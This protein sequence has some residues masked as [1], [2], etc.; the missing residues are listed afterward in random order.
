MRKLGIGLSFL[1]VVKNVCFGEDGLLPDLG[2]VVRSQ[3]CGHQQSLTWGWWL[4]AAKEPLSDR[5]LERV[6]EG[7]ALA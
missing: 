3:T 7:L 5:A 6:H 2:K 4:S 1:S